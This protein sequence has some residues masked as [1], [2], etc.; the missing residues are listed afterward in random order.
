[1]RSATESSSIGVAIE[2][3]APISPSSAGVAVTAAT[4]ITAGSR[5]PAAITC[6]AVQAVKRD[7]WRR[8][9]PAGVPTRFHGQPGSAATR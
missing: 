1:V 9:S 8:T 6:S 3:A 4:A 5:P 2:T 7:T